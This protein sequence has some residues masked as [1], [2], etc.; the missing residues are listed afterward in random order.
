ME[1]RLGTLGFKR[2]EIGIDTPETTKTIDRAPASPE[3]PPAILGS[4]RQMT[5][6]QRAARRQELLNKRGR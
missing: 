1:S 5:P 3:I 6:E 4:V 2:D